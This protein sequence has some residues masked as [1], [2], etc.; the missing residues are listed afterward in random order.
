MYIITE[1]RKEK[2]MRKTKLLTNMSIS[3]LCSEFATI[4]KS[5]IPIT[6]GIFILWEDET[7]KARKQL[8]GTML[9]E[10]ENGGTVQSAF[11]KTESFPDYFL[12]MIAVGEKTGRLDSVLTSLSEYYA[13]MDDISVSVKSAVIYPSVL[14]IT[15]FAVIILLA[16][17]VLPVFSDV[18]AQLGL[19]MS[20]SAVW[21]MDIGKAVSNAAVWIIGSIALVII[22]AVVLY[23]LVPPFR[24]AV[25]SVVSHTKTAKELYG[26]RF[27]NALSMTL[28]SGLDIDEA[29]AMSEKL[30]GNPLMREKIAQCRK[31]MMDGEPFSDAITKTKLFPALYTKMINIGFT[32]GSLDKVMQDIASKTESRVE[33]V[34]QTMV[35]RFEPTMVIIMAVAVGFILISVMLPLLGIMTVIG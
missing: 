23:N 25:L 28:S 24:K 4:V 3:V 8:L 15:V 22:L 17:Y 1:L 14:L 13:R 20:D 34:I 11:A 18:F 29:M 16:V 33:N 5:G 26:A 30:I 31:E 32:T 10:F 27:A 35:S 7:N 2:N 19:T 21:I 9:E 6:D 12:Q